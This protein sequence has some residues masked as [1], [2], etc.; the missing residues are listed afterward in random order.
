MNEKQAAA[1]KAA[2]GDLTPE[3]IHLMAVGGLLAVLFLWSASS[4]VSVYKG[5][6]KGHLDTERATSAV[7]RM[8]VLIV[9]ALFLFAN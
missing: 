4:M 6:A 5:W 7:V 3:W 1:F 2:S 9:M 8:I